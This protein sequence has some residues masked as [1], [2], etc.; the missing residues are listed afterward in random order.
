MPLTGVLGAEQSFGLAVGTLAD[1]VLL[2]P[3]DAEAGIRIQVALL[4]GQRPVD[5]GERGS[6]RHR[7]AVGFQDANVAGEDGHAGTVSGLCEVHRGDVALI[8]SGKKL[9]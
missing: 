4:P 6:H 2:V 7:G 8:E 1:T 5:L 3:S 9:P